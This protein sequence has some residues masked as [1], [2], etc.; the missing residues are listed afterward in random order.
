[1]TSSSQKT[2]RGGTHRMFSAMRKR[3]TYANVAMTLALVFA[4]SGGAYAAKH[5][6]ITSTKQISPKVLKQLQGKA[7]P[8]GPEGKQGPAG[9]EGKAGANGKDGTNGTNG[10]NGESVVAKEVKPGETA[11]NKLGGG[12]FKVGTGAPVY[13]C[14]GQTGFTETLPSGKT[15][16][17]DFVL[18]GN[19]SGAFAHVATAVSFNIPL[20]AAPAAHYIRA[21][22][23]E[24][25]YNSATSKEEERDQPACPGS[26]G[27][28]EAM[29]GNLCV[30]AGQEENTATNP[31][32]SFIFPKVCAFAKGGT[33]LAECQGGQP[34]ADRY[35][36]GLVTVSKEEGFLVVT[37]T[38]A[39]TAE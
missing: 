32:G 29:S 25:F 2:H 28:P 35:G 22:G 17:G 34:A 9:P 4:M 15:E 6:L 39:V 12:E 24:P 10:T 1:M 18:A 36:F 33:P 37:G 3:F 7:G 38:W 13:A 26:V 5:Y 8:V 14:N 21:T 19:A 31:L 23:K 30:Y 20:S 11:C 27:V 16:T